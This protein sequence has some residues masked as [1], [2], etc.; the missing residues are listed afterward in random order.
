MKM[1]GA[2]LLLARAS[3]IRARSR[4]GDFKGYVVSKEEPRIRTDFIRQIVAADTTAGKHGG[5]VVTRFPPEPNGYL[6]IG[7]AKSICLNFGIATEGEGRRCHLRF[8]DTNPAAEDQEYVSAIEQDVRWLG[9]DWGEHRYFASDYYE[10]LF[11]CAEELVRRGH[12]YVCELD[13]DGIREYRGTLTEPGRASPWRDRSSEESLDLLRRMRGGEFPPGSRTLRARIAMDSPVLSMRDP[14]LYRISNASH[15]RRGT[16]WCIYPMYDF[17]HCLS[18]SFEGVTHSLCTLEFADHRPLYDW[19][20]NALDSDARPQ[21]IEFARLNISYTVMSKRL[22]RRLVEEGHVNGWDDP[23]MPTISGM[24]RRGYTSQAIRAFCEE[25]GVAR[26]H[27]MVGLAQLEAAVRTDLNKRAER[28]MAVLRPLKVVITNW[29]EGKVDEL[30]AV[31]NPENADA[32]TRKVSFSGEL[33][34]ERDDFMEDPPRKF[35]RLGPG[36]EVRL[37]YAYF[38]TCQE[39]VKDESGEITELRCTY[40]PATRG[41]DSPDGRK[42]KGTLHWVS[43]AH[44]MDAEV[45]LYEPLFTDEDP[46]AGTDSDGFIERLNPASIEVVAQARL[47]AGLANAKPGD[48]IQFERLGYFTPDPES[49]EGAPIFNRAVTLK[50]AW[51]RLQKR[52]G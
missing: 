39:V 1:A 17:A 15:Y 49:R 31:N 11:E 36:R 46:T 22:L 41:G 20:L 48:P 34:I 32:G 47:E 8:D 25:I 13:A 14:V 27:S 16:E 52:G 37:R 18:D 38:I 50:D 51:A 45:R 30:D 5:Q 9:F 7:H 6:H 3:M 40:D 2:L 23:R 43:A 4:H 42:V 28:R 12:A 19:I 35:F 33:W 29:Q 10:R 24:R 21:Q 26:S 44:A